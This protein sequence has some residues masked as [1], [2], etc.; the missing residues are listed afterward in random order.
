MTTPLTL[1]SY[2]ASDREAC[3][4]IFL[5]NVP[6]YFHPGEEEEYVAALD[7]GA[8]PFL[9][10][11]R[12]GRVAG[13]GGFRLPPDEDV[14]VLAWGMVD[15]AL[16]GQR[17]GEILLLRRLRDLLE[18]SGVRG[19]RVVTTPAIVGFFE[20][21]GFARGHRVAGGIAEGLDAVTLVLEL[22]PARRR[23][24]EA[25]WRRLSSE[26]SRC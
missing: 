3:R 11:E 8:H 23:E 21:Y 19:V 13:C 10:L 17:L 16:H 2:A 25:S 20:R 7:A 22:T 26:I 24:I 14:A 18:L 12:D 6:K 4:R 5:S 1:R 9:V 15:R